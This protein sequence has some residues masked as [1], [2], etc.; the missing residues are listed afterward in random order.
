MHDYIKTII[1]SIKVWVESLFADSKFWVESLF[2][3]STADWNQEDSSQTNY[4]KNK[5]EIAT[6]EDALD[7][8]IDTG[9]L[10]PVGTNDGIIYTTN[11]GV[12]YTLS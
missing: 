7:F 8:L 4:I 10:T 3:S 9:I 1:M 11:D 6:D 2:V 12:I 5:P